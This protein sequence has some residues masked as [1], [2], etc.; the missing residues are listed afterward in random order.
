[1]LVFKDMPLSEVLMRIQ[2]WYDVE[3]IVDKNVSQDI[4]ITLSSKQVLLEKI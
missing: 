3:F 2:R 1:M 4:F